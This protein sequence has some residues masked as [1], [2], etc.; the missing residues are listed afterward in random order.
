MCDAESRLTCGLLH[1]VTN[2]RVGAA[3][4]K[5]SGE[6]GVDFAVARMRL[7]CEQ[8]GR[9]HDLARLA[10]STLR[11]PELE[12]RLLQRMFSVGGEALDRHH[13]A[14]VRASHGRYARAHDL[15]VE[16]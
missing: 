3:A 7:S 12:P 6:G 5:I 10:K 11:H 13:A 9:G 1:R 4:A 14:T 15:A 16:V 8:G 2:S